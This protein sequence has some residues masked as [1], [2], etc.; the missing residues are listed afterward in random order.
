MRRAAPPD[1]LTRRSALLLLGATSGC[2][3]ADV[4]V[5]GVDDE[6]SGTGT[7]GGD[8]AGCRP[9]QDDVLLV[10]RPTSTVS[11]DTWREI[12]AVARERHDAVGGFADVRIHDQRIDGRRAVTVAM[13]R[14]QFDS[15]R[16]LFLGSSTFTV[17]VGTDGDWITVA[18]EGRYEALGTPT[19]TNGT[20]TFAIELTATGADRLTKTVRGTDADLALRTVVD[21]TPVA[22]RPL[23]DSLR[24]AIRRKDAVTRIAAP[25]DEH[26]TFM[27][28]H[29]AGRRPPFPTDIE[30][31]RYRCRDG[32]V[33]EGDTP[34]L[35]A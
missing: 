10:I 3:A 17:A 27:Q 8:V 1:G 32:A 24:R 4:S 28:I 12:A 6:D 29:L 30:T 13:P 26:D 35:D 7:A 20:W 33:D 5:R 25:L 14:G 11:E 2:L 23:S 19:E 15:Q 9:D 31:S 21:G 16:D 18:D 22:R 34:N